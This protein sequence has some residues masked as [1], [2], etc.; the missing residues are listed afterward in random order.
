MYKGNRDS[1]ESQQVM[2]WEWGVL[3]RQ[4]EGAVRTR[5]RASD[6]GGGRWQQKSFIEESKQMQNIDWKVFTVIE[7]K[8]ETG[9]VET[10]FSTEFKKV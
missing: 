6:G 7:K 8:R 3:G 5:R 9:W 4:P 1:W 10:I 2:C